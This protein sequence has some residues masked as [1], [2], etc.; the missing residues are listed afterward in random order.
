MNTFNN[1]SLTSR[2]NPFASTGA[3]IPN[4]QWLLGNVYAPAVPLRSTAE[5]YS[6]YSKALHSLGNINNKTTLKKKV[7]LNATEPSPV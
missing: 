2:R 6:E 7:N 3:T 4:I 1:A 5:I